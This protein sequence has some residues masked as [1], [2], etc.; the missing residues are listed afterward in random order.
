MKEYNNQHQCKALLL[1]AMPISDALDIFEIPFVEQI[2][3]N[4]Y[5]DNIIVEDNPAKPFTVNVRRNQWKCSES[6]ENGHLSSLLNFL[7]FLPKNFDG[8]FHPFMYRIL[9]EYS[10]QMD[11]SEHTKVSPIRIGKYNTTLVMRNDNALRG[12][13][14]RYGLSAV[15]ISNW[16]E[17][18][19]VK[20]KETDMDELRLAFQ[21]DNNEYYV[22]KDGCF[23]PVSEGGIRTQGTRQKDQN[24]YVYENPMDFLAMM[25]LR[26]Q[27]RSYNL[28]KRDYHVI[29]NGDKNI[30]QARQFFKENPDFYEV[31][32]VLP[33]DE[34]GR[35]MFNKLN[36]ACKGTM[37][38]CSNSFEGHASIVGMIRM[39]VPPYIKEMLL[40][41]KKEKFRQE[42][43][44]PKNADS[45]KKERVNNEPDVSKQPKWGKPQTIVIE[46]KKGRLKL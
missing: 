44:L 39:Q 26:R 19:L 43:G 46:N 24:C 17:E 20:N 4:R 14:A 6:G 27:N 33:N 10:K 25:E 45:Y 5:Y 30:E 40:K 13:L 7:G 8:N 21:C 41:Q 23:R 22:F 2:V 35:I 36:E 42:I 31:R 32:S 28:F 34:E 3:P 9:N 1:D 37:V 15:T 12:S 38:N 16:C 29:V 11:L 18:M